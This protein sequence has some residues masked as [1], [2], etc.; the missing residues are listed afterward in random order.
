M[1]GPYIRIEETGAVIP[2]SGQITTIGRGAGVDI[3]LTDP[4]VSRLMGHTC[5][6]RTSDY[7][8]TAPG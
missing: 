2:L 3:Q 6:S 1:E 4:S 7:H 5:T 8:E